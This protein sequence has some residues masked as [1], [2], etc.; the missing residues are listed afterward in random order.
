MKSTPRLVLLAAAALGIAA[1]SYAQSAGPRSG[2]EGPRFER[3]QE[4]RGRLMKARS[5]A[6]DKLNLTESQTAQAEALREEA[7]AKVQAIMQNESLG[8]AERREQIRAALSGQ[9]EKMLAI[10][11]PAQKEQLE[12]MKAEAKAKAESRRTEAMQAAGITPDQQARL[13]SIKESTRA[14]LKSL[15]ENST[16]DREALRAEGKA[17]LETAKAEVQ[18]VLSPEQI[19]KLKSLRGEGRKGGKKPG[20]GGSQGRLGG[21]QA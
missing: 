14:Q 1:A 18:K 20:R 16:L 2:A 7:K 9:R 4:L 8:Q 12:S 6:A 15:R 5:F 3:F 17:I 21:F 19:E 11:T 10:L 13:K